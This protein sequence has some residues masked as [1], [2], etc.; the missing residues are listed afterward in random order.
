MDRRGRLHKVL[1]TV[2]SPDL[3]VNCLAR[4][5]VLARL[6]EPRHEVEI[7]GP[8]LGTEIWPPL[9]DE[10]AYRAVDTN[11]DIARFALSVPELLGKIS[12]D[13]VVVS[14]PRLSSYGVGL[15]KSVLEDVPLVVD[16]DDWETRML[17]GDGGGRS[18]YVSGLAS[19]PLINSFY[20]TRCCERLVRYADETTVSTRVLGEQ[21]GGVVVPHAR[22]TE[23]FSPDRYDKTR[24]REEL[25]L[26]RDEFL[27]M[28]SGTPRPHKG[29]EDLARAVADIGRDDV[30]GVIVGA[31][32]TEYT[33]RIRRTGGEYVRVFGRR[34]FDEIPK[35]IAAADV[36]AIPQRAS[37]QAAGQLPAKLFE[38]MAMGKPIVSTRVSDIPHVLDGC[39][40]VIEPG[41]HEQL[42]RAITDLYRDSSLRDELG[43]AAREKCVEEYSYQALSPVLDEVV[44]RAAAN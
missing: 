13:V 17:H 7:A 16:V 6:L 14:K 1:V 4:A 41:D 9:R 27:V 36:F 42:E 32:E 30:T 44:Q 12:G 26:P 35:W 37:P 15:L 31:P 5:H 3:S 34:D 8:Q 33:E 20:P 43:E 25:G 23:Q 11:R 19:L 22:D 21:F 39:G 38:A 24:V 29:V 40:I 28:F 18:R 2:V 10:Y